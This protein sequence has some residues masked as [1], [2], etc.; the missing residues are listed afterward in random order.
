[1]DPFRHE[2]FILFGMM[3]CVFFI[4]WMF[5]F[6]HRS[7]LYHIHYTLLENNFSLC[8]FNFI[9][10]VCSI[11]TSRETNNNSNNNNNSSNTTNGT[12]E[13]IK[14]PYTLPSTE[15]MKEARQNSANGYAFIILTY[16]KNSMLS[17]YHLTEWRAS[18]FILYSHDNS[19]LSRKSTTFGTAICVKCI[20]FIWWQ[21]TEII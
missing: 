21:P 19:A 4:F 16:R 7:F 6:Y 5:F 1:M 11:G 8:V 15:I 3:V 12:L 2:L 13:R 14:A 9:G 17:L 10:R 20:P 18:P